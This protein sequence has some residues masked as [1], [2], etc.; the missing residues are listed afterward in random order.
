MTRQTFNYA[1]PIACDSN[2]QNVMALDL[3]TDEHYVLTPKPVTRATPM[4]FEPKQVQSARG[5]KT[6]TSHEA[7]NYSNAELINFWNCVLFTKHSDTTLMLLGKGI[8][9][10]FLATSEQLPNDFYSLPTRHRFNLYNASKVG[11]H[12]HLLNLALLFAPDWFADAF[13]TL[14]GFPC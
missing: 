9:C 14:F 6:F 3:D 13:N 2:S 11:L 7:G 1:T 5:G 12:D 10:D 4:F 8:S